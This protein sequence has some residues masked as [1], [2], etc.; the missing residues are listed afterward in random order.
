MRRVSVMRRELELILAPLLIPRAVLDA[1]DEAVLRSLP[2]E[3]RKAAEH[4]L[5]ARIEILRAASELINA[6]IKRLEER[7]KEY[8]EVK[9]EEVKVE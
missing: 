5:A 4:Y 9:K 7:L 3:Y 2:E 8:R 1:I 6:R